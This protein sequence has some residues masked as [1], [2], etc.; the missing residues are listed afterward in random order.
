MY[1]YLYEFQ[2]NLHDAVLNKRTII[3][4]FESYEFLHL[5]IMIFKRYLDIH[6]FNHQN[7][8]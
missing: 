4:N 2:L 8:S 6:K 1:A 3:A 5:Y 7:Q